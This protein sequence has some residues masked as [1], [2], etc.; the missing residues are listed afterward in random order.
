MSFVT[1]PYSGLQLLELSHIWGHGVPSYPGQDDVKMYR[2]VKH[3]QHGVLAW[4]TSTVMH[5]GTHMNAPLHLIQRGADLS[6][7]PVDRF[8]GNGVVLYIPKGPYEVINA[9]DLE[10]ASPGVQQGDI[11]VIV[12]GWHHKYSD[13]LEYFG[14]APGLSKDA[15]EW[16]VKKECKMVAVDTPQ[17]DHPLATSLG[18]HRGGPLMK[19]LAEEYQ[20]AT[21]LDPKKEH[22]EWNIAH[23]TLLGAGIPTIEQVGGDVD[24]LLGKRATFVATPWK[25]RKG[26]ACPVRFVAMIDPTGNCR[27]D[28][29]KE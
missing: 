12:T 29:G 2:S 28:S 25:F 16:L 26:D 20:K 4:K 7:I 11:V 9:K 17:I 13:S 3:A 14:Q 21:G 6:Q 5:T 8:F 1:D 27:I 15:A 23:K 10:N 22:G 24:L 18:P 19:R